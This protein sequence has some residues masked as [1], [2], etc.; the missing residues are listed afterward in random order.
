MNQHS[1][2]YSGQVQQHG[3]SSYY[4]NTQ[5][6]SSAMQQVTHLHPEF[7]SFETDITVSC[8]LNKYPKYIF[9]D[10]CPSA[11]FPVVPAKLWFRWRPAP[12]GT[13]SHSSPGPTSQHQQTT[14]RFSALQ[15]HYGPQP[16]HD[17][18][19]EQQGT[20]FYIY[21]TFR[22]ISCFAL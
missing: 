13:P 22:R 14:P 12:L 8:K 11:G 4:S 1:N 21:R 5:S 3:Q 15:R 20:G 16:Q 19:S 18:A 7:Y 17:A 2:M 10:D 6:P 9:L